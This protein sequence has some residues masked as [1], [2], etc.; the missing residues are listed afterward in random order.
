[1]DEWR[2]G[3]CMNAHMY[4]RA[5][6]VV[7]SGYLDSAM[8]AVVTAVREVYN[9]SEPASEFNYFA[10]QS[11]LFLPKALNEQTSQVIEYAFKGVAKWVYLEEN[12]L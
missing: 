6:N 1:M 4:L 11:G 9:V 5:L 7:R 2:L 12:T 10:E 3:G 8:L